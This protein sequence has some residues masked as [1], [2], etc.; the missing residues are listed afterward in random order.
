MPDGRCYV[1]GNLSAYCVC[2]KVEPVPAVGTEAHCF[3]NHD[4]YCYDC[5]RCADCAD[6]ESGAL[7]RANALL[8]AVADDIGGDYLDLLAQEV[9][10]R[11]GTD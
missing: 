9:A 6:E 11:E 1:C 10:M 8:D 4:N 3:A 5:G 7:A 2:G